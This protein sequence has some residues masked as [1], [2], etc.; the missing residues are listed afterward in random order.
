MMMHCLVTV[1]CFMFIQNHWSL[2]NDNSGGDVYDLCEALYD[3]SAKCHK[4]LSEDSDAY[5]VSS[6]CRMM[7]GFKFAVHTYK[8]MNYSCCVTPIRKSENQEQTEGSVCNFIQSLEENHYDEYGEINLAN[9]YFD[10][11][12]WADYHQYTKFVSP[13]QIVCLVVSILLFLG[14]L[15]YSCCLHNALTQ[16]ARARKPRGQR[17]FTGSLLYHKQ[18]PP[19]YRGDQISP[20]YSGITKHRS[21]GDSSESAHTPSCEDLSAT[22]SQRSD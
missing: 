16:P 14:L 9:L 5:E 3:T 8:L 7:N 6:L 15:I 10:T 19:V 17:D 22:S 20:V 4:Y 13:T 1:H 18:P 11:S 21:H 2:G 12:K